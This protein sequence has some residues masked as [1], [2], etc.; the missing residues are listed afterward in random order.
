MTFRQNYSHP[1]YIKK[2]F[3]QHENFVKSFAQ[4]INPF[5]FQLPTDQLFNIESRKPAVPQVDN[6]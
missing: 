3:D 2:R 4:Y 1:I 6:F 5:N